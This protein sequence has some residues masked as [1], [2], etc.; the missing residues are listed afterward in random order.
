MTPREAGCD[1]GVA[2]STHRVGWPTTSFGEAQGNVQMPL[3]SANQA[4]IRA[5]SR[6]THPATSRDMHRSDS[7][8]TRTTHRRQLDP[9][10]SLAAGSPAVLRTWARAKSIWQ[11]LP[12]TTTTTLCVVVVG[13]R[14][15]ST[16]RRR[17]DVSFTTPP[18][19]RHDH[20]TRT[21]GYPGQA[22]RRWEHVCLGRELRPGECA[23]E[24]GAF[25]CS[26]LLDEQPG[27]GHRRHTMTFSVSSSGA[28]SG[29]FMYGAR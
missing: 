3:R 8:T 15:H 27:D 4:L 11:W 1:V 23:V 18:S 25:V 17:R 5:S 14:S 2:R 24:W 13:C 20:H 6:T 21:V 22:P 28:P 7:R 12:A 9:G 16:C 29:P 10:P 19:R 26:G